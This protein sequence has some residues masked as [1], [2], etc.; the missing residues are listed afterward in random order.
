MSRQQVI[1]GRITEFFSIY[2]DAIV[3]IVRT[4]TH[5]WRSS[6]RAPANDWGRSDYAF[7]RRAA[8]GRAK[9]LELSGL[10][11]KPISNK[12]AAW[13]LGRMPRW[14]CEDDTSQKALAEWWT[15]H[16][17]E[18]LTAYRFA[19]RQG[20]SVIVVNSDLSI[21]ILRPDDVDPIVDDNDFGSIVGWRVTQ[22]LQHPDNAQR[23]TI[24]DEYRIEQRTQIILLDGAERRRTQFPN[25]IGML[26]VILIANHV[27][28]GQTFGKAEADG[29]LPLFHRYGEVMDAAIEGNILQGRPTPVVTFKDL[30]AQ[31]KFWELYGSTVNR[32]LPDGTSERV[33][34]LDVDLSQILTVT[35]GE[36]DYKSPGN[37]SEDTAKLLEILFYLILEHAEIPEFVFGNAISSS[38]ASA[39]AQLPVFEK[40][41]LGEQGEAKAWLVKI[42]EVVLA[43]LSFIQPGVVAQT[44]VL[45]W[46]QTMQDGKLTLETLKWAYLEAKLI[47][48]RTTLMLAPI[49]VEDIDEVLELAE[50][51]GIEMQAQA[52]EQARA[53]TEAT[54]PP[55]AEEGQEEEPVPA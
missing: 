15:D 50:A 37:F 7:W 41:I 51:E 49:E 43:Y 29:L 35:N 32:V 8:N 9:G 24:I 18:I 1:W 26:P 54:A 13:A 27:E 28:D 45:Q 44:P 52:I 20:D 14:K 22:N 17:S 11:I 19:K 23:M 2:S 48:R 42:A 6:F 33:V 25:L 38:K 53:M 16:H 31:N 3:T 46:P 21:T 36:F 4:H 39:D 10:F 12:I 47:D 40:F 55:E 5:R 34:S 30:A